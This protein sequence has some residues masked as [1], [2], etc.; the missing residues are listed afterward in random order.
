MKWGDIACVVQAVMSKRADMV[1]DLAAQ[2]APEPL[3]ISDHVDGRTVRDDTMAAWRL[4]LE[5]DRPWVLRFEDDVRLAPGFHDLALSLIEAGAVRGDGI[6][7]LYSSREVRDGEVLPWPP[8][9]ERKGSSYFRCTPA[10]AMPRE[11]VESFVAFV[12]ETR[13]DIGLEKDF[14]VW[15]QFWLQAYRLRWG[16]ALPSIVQHLG[17][18]ISLVGHNRN[19]QRQAHT[20]AAIWG[21]Q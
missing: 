4:G 19:P 15:M 10:V 9:L 11:Y 1:G 18:A 20:Y 21:D 16:R 8:I 3:A 6:V 14:D 5:A 7:S 17:N 2:L 12:D 13:P